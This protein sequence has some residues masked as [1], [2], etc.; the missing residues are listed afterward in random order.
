MLETTLRNASLA[1]LGR[2]LEEQKD[3]KRDVVCP[4]ADIRAEGGLLSVPGL[5]EA[6][7][8]EEGVE[9]TAGLVRPTAVCDE[10]L[11]AKLGIP[12]AYLRDTRAA[13]PVL[14]VP[15]Y[16]P[17]R[18][19]GVYDDGTLIDAM[20]NAHL[21]A[22]GGNV[23]VR[24]FRGLPTD[25]GGDGIGIARSVLSDRFALGLDNIDVLYSCL[26]AARSADIEIAVE[27]IDLSERAMR[28]MFTAPQITAL[29]PK[30]L[31]G[32]RSP[33]TPDGRLPG[34]GGNRLGAPGHEYDPNVVFAGFVLSNSE[35]G[36]GAF[37]IVPR[38]VVRICRNGLTINRDALRHVHLGGK[39][40]QGLVRWSDETQAK[41]LDLIAAKT[42]DAVTTFLDRDYMERALD[43]IEEK[44]EAPVSTPDATI[45]VIAQKLRYSEGERETL[46][47][48]FISGAQ[49]TAGGILNAVTSMA[50]TVPDPDRAA[51]IEAGALDALAL[52]AS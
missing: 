27:K 10:T 7:I 46:L 35:T 2:V 48:H 47:S 30:L 11:A 51:E 5:G 24:A 14:T 39:L 37:Q 22:H 18:D 36:G 29:A 52:A 50:Q 33:F 28:V 32:Y 17:D 15:G 45:R 13:G 38:L 3:A 20:L 25:E 41:N 40:E 26:E 4:A 8:S 42:R 23:L 31:E 16:A 34:A 43:A 6:Q 9:L 49:A 1:D 44:A 12:T 21:Q 19:L